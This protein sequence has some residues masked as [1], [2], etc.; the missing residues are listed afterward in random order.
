VSAINDLSEWERHCVVGVAS[1]LSYSE[2]G[3][4]RKVDNTLYVA[5]RK[6]KEALS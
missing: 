4:A 1:G 2:I 5:R 3:N 6:L